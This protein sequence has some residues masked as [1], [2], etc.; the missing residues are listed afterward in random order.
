M[1]AAAATISPVLEVDRVTVEFNVSARTWRRGGD[2]LRAVDDVSL[3]LAAGEVLGLVGESGCGKTTLG[4]TIVGLHTPAG[5][6]IRFHG[7]DVHGLRGDR[8]MDFRRRAQIVFQDPYA[9]LN[10]RMTVQEIIREPLRTHRVGDRGAQIGRVAEV[11]SLVGVDHEAMELYPHAFSGGQRQRICI[12]RALALEPELIVADEPVSALD[13]SI[14]AQVVNLIA[15]IQERL[16]LSMIFIAHDLAVVRHVADRVAVMYLGA[17]VETGTTAEVFGAAAHP[18]TQALLAAVP[19]PDPVRERGRTRP[20]LTG[21]VPSP[22]DLPTG[23]RFH[24]RCPI[25]MEICRRVSPELE[26]VPGG[27]PRHVTACHAVASPRRSEGGQAAIRVPPTQG[28][29]ST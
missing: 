27:S 8:L 3:Q 13:V 1:S 9:S 20:A 7:A 12:A 19:I 29:K 17:I 14:Q 5:G 26:A 10:P 28:A 6:T 22:I 25:A 4:R 15:D 18:Y 2:R 16:G 11:L 24:T 23:C 21:D